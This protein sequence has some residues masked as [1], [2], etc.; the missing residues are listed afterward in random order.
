MEGIHE[1]ALSGHNDMKW[2]LGKLIGAGSYGKVGVDR[3]LSG[4]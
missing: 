3:H 2:T 1:S 4:G